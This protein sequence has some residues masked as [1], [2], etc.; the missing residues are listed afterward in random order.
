MNWEQFFWG[1]NEEVPVL[2]MCI[3]AVIVFVAIL[4]LM[5]IAG[6]RTFGKKKAFDI[7][8]IFMLGAIMSRPVVGASP[9]LASFAACFTM[10]SIH[11]VL[12]WVSSKNEMLGKLI[13][14]EKILLFTN[15]QFLDANMRKAMISETDLME[16]VRLQTSKNDLAGIEEIFMERDGEISV[17]K[18]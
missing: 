5:R 8:V 10:V 15:G 1:R 2:E 6:L 17:V 11:R 14:G 4:V 13:K 3:R 18:K 12:G 16:G 7:I 9:F